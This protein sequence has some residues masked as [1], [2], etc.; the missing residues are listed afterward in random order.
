MCS[1]HNSWSDSKDTIWH[2]FTESH[3]TSAKMILYGQ[4]NNRIT[5]NK[6]SAYE[7]RV[8]CTLPFLETKQH[9]HTVSTNIAQKS[10]E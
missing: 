9:H 2:Y 10:K 4:P 6:S 1:L 3:E 7:V 5:K 8:K